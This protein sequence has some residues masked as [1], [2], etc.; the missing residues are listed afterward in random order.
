LINFESLIPLHLERG[1]WGSVA[2][3]VAHGDLGDVDIQTKLY[4]DDF[5]DR[6][7]GLLVYRTFFYIKS[8]R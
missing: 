1:P 2:D 7:L 6:S 3:L 4:F 5:L 8:T